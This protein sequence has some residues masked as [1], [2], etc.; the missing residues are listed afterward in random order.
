MDPVDYVIQVQTGDR[1]YA[2]T[3]ANVRVI[4]HGDNGRCTDKMKLSNMFKDDFEQGKLDTFV[5]KKQ[6]KLRN[7]QK[8]E[9]WR[10]NF[11]LGSDW[12]VDFISVRRKDQETEYVFPIFRWVPS[13]LHMYFR[14]HDTML[15]QNDPEAAQRWEELKGKRERYIVG[16]KIPG[17]PAQVNRMRIIT[18]YPTIIFEPFSKFWS[19]YTR[20]FP[21]KMCYLMKVKWD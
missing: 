1:K 4:L 7:I 13:K 15:P 5:V 3:D 8:L 17:G 2:G 6:F 11:G 14:V 16:Q 9:L 20:R 12:F 19:Q 21:V 18:C 10:D